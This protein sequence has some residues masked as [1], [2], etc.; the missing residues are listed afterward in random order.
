MRLH[1][2]LLFAAA[3]LAAAT[4]AQAGY[5]IWT[6][7]YTFTRQE[8]QQAVDK[9]F[10]ATLRYAQVV[11]VQLTHP[12]LVLDDA[13]NRITTQVDAQLTNA[14]AV[15][16]PVNG[17]LSLNSGLRYDKA[18]RAVLLDNPTV[19][20]V[21][22]QG[23]ALYKE[24]LNAIGA[25]VAQQL[26]KDYPIYTFKPDELRFGGKEVEPGAITVAPEGIRV[27]VKDR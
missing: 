18:Q 26:L 13:N 11:S 15:S 4:A 6:G 3:T 9:R 20:D 8:L 23:M 25:V 21:E 12:R 22:V 7:E 24:Q 17:T 10:P 5:N 16:P 14:L 19:Q 27:E 1:R 2:R